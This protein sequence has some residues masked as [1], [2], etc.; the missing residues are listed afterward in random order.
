MIKLRSALLGFL[1]AFA[2]G[3]LLVWAVD[4]RRMLSDLG[5]TETSGRWSDDEAFV[6]VSSRDPVWGSRS[7]PATIV[8][9]ADIEGGGTAAMQRALELLKGAYGKDKLR[10]VWKN[11][12]LPQRKTSR[13]SA[14]AAET[15]RALQGNEAFFKFFATASASP[16]A[17][18]RENFE[19]WAVASGVPLDPFRKALDKA[20]FAAKVDADSELARQLHL[21]ASPAAF[22]N[23]VPL[24]TA[25]P[26]H[27]YRQAI[28]AQLA[29]A[30]QLSAAGIKPP[31][32]YTELCRYNRAQADARDSRPPAPTASEPRRP[33]PPPEDTT[34]WH[35]PLDNAPV[36]GNKKA[37]VTIVVFGDYQ[38]P[39]CKRTEELL[40]QIRTD[41]GD[42]VRVVWK[43]RVQIFHPRSE[44]AAEFARE[45]RKQKG[46]AG[47]WAAH[48]KLFENNSRLEDADL[49]GYAAEL[50]LDVAKVKSAIAKKSHELDIQ[51]D[52][53][54]SD[55]LKATATPHLFVNGRRLTGGQAMDQLRKLIDA[56]LA[57]AET[58]IAAG[59][60]ADKVYDKVMADA[61]KPPAPP[62]PPRKDVGAPG[63]DNP[64]R[65]PAN[66]T[67]VIQVFSDFQCPY[68]NQARKTLDEV[69]ER[70]G[71][72][73]RIV[74]RNKPQPTHPDAPLA[75]EAAMEAFAQKGSDGFWKFHDLLFDNQA[76]SGGLK[77]EALDRYAQQL[78]LDPG[79]FKAALDARTH[80]AAVDSDT[81]T[82][83]T[84]GISATP[85]FAINSYVLSGA[86][87]LSELR[88]VIAHA[89]KEQN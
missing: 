49:L 58:L 34:T 28:D 81:R 17:L 18:T 6:P 23:C 2:A 27:R 20:T 25:Q 82:A 29:R 21:E 67:V 55:A 75:A 46:E 40:A 26:I 35:V 80:K 62:L 30:E 44:P 78:G 60:P 16:Q 24:G 9:F 14:I 54:Q 10:I 77:R 7:A 65:G 63:K 4:F 89:L 66:A 74:W 32:L 13:P 12:V 88:K 51:A 33:V 79:K 42:K 8:V 53:D 70:F 36:R 38:C 41:Y 1:L 68:C 59:T 50:G 37:P 84:A 61:V 15:A 39:F 83:E 69:R 57:Q 11:I 76:V 48:D 73:V 52:V 85:S 47:F 22:L 86:A 56:Q 45:A 19:K 64:S 31:H 72:Q 71:K 43:D 3:V 87:P 5:T